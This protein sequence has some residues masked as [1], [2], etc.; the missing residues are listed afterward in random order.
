MIALLSLVIIPAIYAEPPHSIDKAAALNDLIS[1]ASS[2]KANAVR[3]PGDTLDRDVIFKWHASRRVGV[4]EQQTMHISHGSINMHGVYAVSADYASD[5]SAA[6]T[7]ADDEQCQKLPKS[8]HL[9]YSES[10][11]DLRLGLDTITDTLRALRSRDPKARFFCKAKTRD[12]R[13]DAIRALSSEPSSLAVGN[14]YEGLVIHIGKV[15]DKDGSLELTDVV[16]QGSGRLK[17]IRS[18]TLH[19]PP[20]PLY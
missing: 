13:S 9:I 2:V 1:N 7:K 15:G 3:Q 10:F 4:C 20:P 16:M 5:R 19:S 14:S 18:A 11:S 6:P 12:C 17:V 8:S